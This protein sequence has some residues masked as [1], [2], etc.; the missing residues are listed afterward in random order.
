MP[1]LSAYANVQFD[2]QPGIQGWLLAHRFR[3]QTYAYAASTAGVALPPYDFQTYPD[4][5]WFARHANAHL[6]LQSFMIPDNTV[7][8]TVL[9][10]Y[11]WDNS[12]DFNT[13]MQMHTL[14]HMRLDQGFGLFP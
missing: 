7:N 8:L 5:D 12:D 14:I 9:G 3:H 6:A 4:D 13:F 10:N 1:S 11:T 2:D